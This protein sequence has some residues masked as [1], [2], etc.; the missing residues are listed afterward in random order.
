MFDESDLG[1]RLSVPS[2]VRSST[3]AIR[4]ITSPLRWSAIGLLGW[5]HRHTLAL[6][7]RSFGAAF[8][9]RR[10]SPRDLRNLATALVRIAFDGRLSNARGLRRV[11]VV[12]DELEADYEAGWPMADVVASV[13]RASSPTNGDSP[14]ASVQHPGAEMTGHA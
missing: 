3:R 7:I 6:W 4:R 5:S 10:S 14:V 13:L 8:A 1:Y 9:G 12:G 2:L 11:R